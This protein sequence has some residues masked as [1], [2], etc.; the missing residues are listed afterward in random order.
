MKNNLIKVVLLAGVILLPIACNPKK[1]DPIAAPVVD[2]EQIKNEIQ[3]KENEFAELYNT[4]ELRNIG[5]YADDATTFAQNREPLVGKAAIVAY[6]KEGIASSPEGNKISFTTNEV[7]VSNDGNQVVE[8]LKETDG[9]TNHR[10]NL[11]E[12]CEM[13]QKNMAIISTKLS[14]AY[15]SHSTYQ[16]QGSKDGFQFE[17]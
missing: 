7:F 3:A 9:D 4:G 13:L 2:I 17:V 11:D 6:L 14:A 10:K 12:F 16:T 8:T 15:F 1:E 5:Y